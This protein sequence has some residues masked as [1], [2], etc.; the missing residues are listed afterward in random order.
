[1]NAKLSIDDGQRVRSH[2]AGPDRAVGGF[3]RLLHQS[4][5]SSSVV[6]SAGPRHGE[7]SAAAFN[8]Y[9]AGYVARGQVPRLTALSPAPRATPSDKWCVGGE[10]ND[11]A[12]PTA[13]CDRYRRARRAEGGRDWRPGCRVRSPATPFAGEDRSGASTGRRRTSFPGLAPVCSPRSK[14]GVPA[15]RVAS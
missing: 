2:L 9:P 15:T 10:R 11:K 4:R 3:C 13:S 14:T 8:R 1:M 6:R 5:I 12:L 7:V